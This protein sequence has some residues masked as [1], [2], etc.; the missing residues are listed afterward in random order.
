MWNNERKK[1]LPLLTIIVEEFGENT[2]GQR[3]DQFLASRSDMPSRSQIKRYCEESRVSLNGR[4]A[5]ISDRV[6]PGDQIL[7]RLPQ[8]P[9]ISLEPRAVDLKI[10]HEDEDLVVLYKPRSLSMH[11]GSSRSDETTLVHALLHHFQTLSDFG[12]LFRPGIVHRLDKNTEGI[13]VVAKNNW[14]H[15]RLAQQF[16]ER[17]VIRRYWALCWGKPPEVME[18]DLPIGRHRVDRKKMAIDARG[19]TSQS[20]FR[21]LQFF[22]EDYS[23]MECQL[24]TGRTHQI[25]VH[26]QARGFPLLADPVYGLKS[27]EL[28]RRLEGFDS[29]KEEALRGLVGQALVAFELG[30]TH[31]RTQDEIYFRS[32]APRWLQILTSE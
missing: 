21:R 18:I 12:G 1:D 14:T 15:E 28:K 8:S 5:K 31:P 10:F 17:K 27:A 24:R 25:R 23:W 4:I 9:E 3:I 11:P 22:K 19:R 32:E 7:V 16:S 20:V 29:K 2:K 13:V 26:A 30:F 6:M